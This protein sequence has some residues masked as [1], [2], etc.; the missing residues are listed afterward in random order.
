MRCM[1]RARA[2]ALFG[3]LATVLTVPAAWASGTATPGRVRNLTCGETIGVMRFPYLGNSQPRYQSRLVLGAA[4]VP[5]AYLAQVVATHDQPWRYWRKAGLVI[6]SGSE[7]VTLTVPKEWRN[8]AAIVWGNGGNGV[9]SFRS[10]H[11]LR[12]QSPLW[13]RLR[14]R[15]LPT[16]VV[17]L[18][19]A[20]RPRRNTHADCPI[21]HRSAVPLS[22]G[23]IGDSGDLPGRWRRRASP[24]FLSGAAPTSRTGVAPHHAR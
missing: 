19:A 24:V 9:F 20:D 18:S 4:S 7:R 16:V 21:W 13:E 1:P 11:R 5:P 17:S 14:R 3:F 23:A 22:Y 15:L 8:R 2:L 6:R 12:I 10:H